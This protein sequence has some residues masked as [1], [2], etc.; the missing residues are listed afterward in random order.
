MERLIESLL[1]CANAHGYNSEY[2]SE[3]NQVVVFGIGVPLL[4]DLRDI[5]MAFYG[6]GCGD[7]VDADDSWGTTTIYLDE[8]EFLDEVDEDRLKM[9]LPRK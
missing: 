7:C 9:A 6:I 5:V 3:Y 8:Y 2:V 4:S 1:A